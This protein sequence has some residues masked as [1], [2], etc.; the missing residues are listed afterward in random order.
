MR[1]VAIAFRCLCY[2]AL[3]FVGSG[4]AALV[5]VSHMG[6]CP[7]LDEGAI[8]CHS[9]FYR[10]VGGYGLGVVYASLFTGLPALLAFC[11]F[12]MLIRRA[13]RL[14]RGADARSVD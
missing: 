14:L 4:I 3:A 10:S 2:L 7:R 9:D 12:V 1:V 13:W 8:E 5:L 11:G 6:G